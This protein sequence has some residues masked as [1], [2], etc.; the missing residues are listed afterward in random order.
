MYKENPENNVDSS[1]ISYIFMIAKSF[2]IPKIE[3][4]FH[5]INIR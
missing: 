5:E 1:T 4:I 2:S 3:E